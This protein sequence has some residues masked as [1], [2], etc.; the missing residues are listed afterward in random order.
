MILWVMNTSKGV[1]RVWVKSSSLLRHRVD[2]F[3]GNKAV[4]ISCRPESCQET[5]IRSWKDI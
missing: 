2:V 4:S 5:K 1:I 3:E